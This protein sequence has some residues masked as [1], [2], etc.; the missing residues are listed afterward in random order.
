M[1]GRDNDIEVGGVSFGGGPSFIYR[2]QEVT[3]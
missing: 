2:T 3:T 1:N